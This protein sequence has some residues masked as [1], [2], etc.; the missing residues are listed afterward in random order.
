MQTHLGEGSNPIATSTPMESALELVNE[1]PS[2]CWSSTP[3]EVNVQNPQHCVRPQVP[4]TD[5]V[6]L[7]DI[8]DVLDW[9]QDLIELRNFGLFST[10][11][12]R[13]RGRPT[14]LL[15]S[16]RTKYTS[17][18]DSDGLVDTP[19]FEDYCFYSIANLRMRISSF[20]M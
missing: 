5:V 2:S 11:K 14:F 8:L 10:S 15:E 6:S 9:A 1:G 16:Y 12:K 7:G 17:Q 3:L 13:K 18:V 20:K 19:L 4:D